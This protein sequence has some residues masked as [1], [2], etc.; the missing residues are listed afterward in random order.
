MQYKVVYKL[1]TENRV[2]D[3]LSRREHDSIQCSSLSVATPQWCQAV[4]DGYLLDDATQQLLTK[5]TVDATSVPN[6]SLQDGLLR[7]KGRV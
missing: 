3:A 7:F 2:A 6:F 1:G 4:L 5:L